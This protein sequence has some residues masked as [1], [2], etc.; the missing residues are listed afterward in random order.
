MTS[1]NSPD[2]YSPDLGDWRLMTAG[3]VTAFNHVPLD[4]PKSFRASTWFRDKTGNEVSFPTPSAVALHLNAAWKA[5]KRA[6]AIKTG[7]MNHLLNENGKLTLQASEDRVATLFDYFEEMIAVAFGSYG[8]IEAFCNQ[9]IVERGG[10]AVTVVT[11]KKTKVSK[12]PEEVEREQS[13][14]EKLG[15]IVPALLG[16]RTP[17]G[18]GVW[19]IY[20]GMKHIRDA[21]THFKRR[22][23]ARHADQA[24]EP[25]A[26]LELYRIDCFKLPED[27]MRILRY[28]QSNDDVQRWMMN[29]AWS[30]P[31]SSPAE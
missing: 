23:Q 20:L 7:L 6:Q 16:I 18:L 11:K 17:R 19:D 15:R 30:R 4:E 25:T 31:I 22:D 29:P 21:V 2:K 9:T 10:A 26:L 8:A 24:N 14:D 3:W 13:T 12:T 28:F 5:S 1:R 27:A